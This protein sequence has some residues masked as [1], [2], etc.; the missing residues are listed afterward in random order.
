MEEKIWKIVQIT[1]GNIAKWRKEDA[2]GC[3]YNDENDEKAYLEALE[4]LANVGGR[5][6][7]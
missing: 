1:N 7:K 4:F 5:T 6:L 3:N 2:G